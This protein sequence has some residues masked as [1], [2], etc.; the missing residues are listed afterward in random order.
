LLLILS[1]KMVCSFGTKMTKRNATT[2]D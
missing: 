2:E 1:V